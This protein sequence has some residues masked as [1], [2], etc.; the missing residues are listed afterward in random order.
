MLWDDPERIRRCHLR[1]LYID[2]LKRGAKIKEVQKFSHGD[3]FCYKVTVEIMSLP[4][5]SPDWSEFVSIPH[6]REYVLQPKITVWDR[7]YAYVTE[8]DYKR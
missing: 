3:R 7:D 2:I 6:T 5:I 1:D 8:E 4:Y